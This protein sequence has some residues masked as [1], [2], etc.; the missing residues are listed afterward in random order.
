MG[1]MSLPNLRVVA[2]IKP[3]DTWTLPG[4]GPDHIVDSHLR[5]CLPFHT[6]LKTQPSTDI[7][8]LGLQ[9]FLG[10]EMPV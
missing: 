6:E 7:H 1:I 2:R 10:L 3:N 5:L 4:T 9:P 8:L